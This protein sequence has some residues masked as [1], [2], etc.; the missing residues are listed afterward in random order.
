MSDSRGCAAVPASTR[1]ARRVRSTESQS[2]TV[3]APERPV[4]LN[5][6]TRASAAAGISN[7]AAACVSPA[8]N[9]TSPDAMAD[10]SRVCAETKAR[11]VPRVSARARR[12]ET[13]SV[14][15]ERPVIATGPSA[16]AANTVSGARSA[17]SAAKAVPPPSSSP[18]LAQ[19]IRAGFR[20][21]ASSRFSASSRSLPQGC[22][23]S[24]PMRFPRS[25]FERRSA[26]SGLS[27]CGAVSSMCTAVSRS[28]ASS[29]ALA[30]LVSS[31]QRGA[32]GQPLSMTIRIG[33][34]SAVSP[35]RAPG[36]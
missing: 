12:T 4:T 19:K 3:P 14:S 20:P 8:A 30:A 21:D 33:P 1:P 23:C 18:S 22:G 11:A 24:V 9:N 28:P 7:S 31:F 29:V 25:A 5:R 26:G 2:Q 35:L 27:C 10:P 15:A 17:R 13:A 6:A 36:A 16:G 34:C 32:A